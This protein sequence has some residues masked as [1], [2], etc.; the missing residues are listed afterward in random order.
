MCLQFLN[1]VILAEIY[2]EK[3]GQILKGVL[4]LSLIFITHS[5]TQQSKAH[6]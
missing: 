3:Q 6:L 5:L 1:M 2:R 4:L